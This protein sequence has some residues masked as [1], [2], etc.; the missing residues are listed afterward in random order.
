MPLT[1]PSLAV[2]DAATGGA[3]TATLAGGAAG[4]ANTL[5][6]SQMSGAVGV[7]T[8]TAAG[9]RTGDGTITGTAAVGF[10]VWQ[11]QSVLGAEQAWSA[12]YYQR[13]S[14]SADSLHEQLQQAALARI[15]A[16]ALPGGYGA[17]V[18]RMKLPTGR[19]LGNLS[20]PATLLLTVGQTEEYP[21]TGTTAHDDTVLPLYVAFL[22]GDLDTDTPDSTVTLCR[23]LVRRAFRCQRLLGDGRQYSAS[24]AP[25]A[26]IEV[27][28]AEGKSLQV[29]ALTL[30]LLCREPRGIGA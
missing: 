29:S 10:Y 13:V 5:Y 17:N 21:E 14:D 28:D 6:R 12:P 2:A 1:A 20:L 24:F 9:T 11:V 16:L 8:Q 4:A 7:M 18:R 25:D 15:R 26:V 23:Q 30:R 27:S 22:S 3:F 19:R